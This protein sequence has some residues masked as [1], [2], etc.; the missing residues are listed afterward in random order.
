MQQIDKRE[1]LLNL[2]TILLHTER[3]L[4]ADELRQRVPGYDPDGELAAFRR[5]FE[6]DKDDLR[7]MGVPLRTEEI[8]YR[9]PPVL[10]Y[11]I[12][13]SE[14]YL[15]DPG[16]EPDELAALRFA[17]AAVRFDGLDRTDP[18][19]A[20]LRLGSASAAVAA[21]VG[22]DGVSPPVALRTELPTSPTVAALFTAIGARR[23]VTFDYS[24]RAR[25]VD[26]HRLDFRGGRWYLT[27]RDRE[28]DATRVFRIDRIEG[29]PEVTSSTASTP[30]AAAGGPA[31][32][33]EFESV[34]EP[35]DA[36]VLIDPPQAPWAEQVL[37]PEAVSERRDDGSLVVTLRVTNRVGLRNFVL[38]FLDG[39]EVLEPAELRADITGWL[40]GLAEPTAERSDAR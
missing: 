18:D 29:T 31:Q 20:L 9:D 40:G 35:L 4:S 17:V 34:E 14:Y 38:G 22:P 6:R 23:A 27:G 3:P 7:E 30:D 2:V 8:P 32:P 33:W 11:R 5:A 19:D 21:E 26:P 39:A 1:R 16:L 28:L 36:V 12:P 13:R 25:S 37:G 15:P 10:G 24:G